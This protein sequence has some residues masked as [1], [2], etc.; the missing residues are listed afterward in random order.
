[1]RRVWVRGASGAGKS[2]LAAVLAEALD[3]P[4]VMVDEL[5]FLPGWMPRPLEDLRARVSAAIG[6]GGWVVDGNWTAAI[7]PLVGPLVD[8]VVWVDPPRWLVMRRLVV[9]TVRRW[10][11]RQQ[12]Y[13]GNRE[14]L[15][16]H[17]ALWD[18]ER[19]LWRWAWD[20]HAEARRTL[21][22]QMADPDGPRWIRVDL[23]AIS[24]G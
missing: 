23:R 9:R 20:A 6:A 3:V 18:P 15:L 8:T 14:T 19:S 2:T 17:L 7:E 22:A 21:P 12:L 5:A 4:H 13:G 16:R 1:M 11:T 10:M 24:G